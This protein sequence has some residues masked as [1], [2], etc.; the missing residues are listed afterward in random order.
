[1]LISLFLNNDICNDVKSV[2]KTLNGV[3]PHINYYVFS[4]SNEEAQK[5]M[6]YM[7]INGCIGSIDQCNQQFQ[8]EYQVV[9]SI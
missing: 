4:Q 2:L 1:M 6:S 3:I 8:D 9:V 7:D 5:Y